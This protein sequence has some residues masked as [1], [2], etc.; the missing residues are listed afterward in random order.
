MEMYHESLIDVKSQNCFMHDFVAQIPE[1]QRYDS[2]YSPYSDCGIFGHYFFGDPKF[3]Q[4]M[5]YA[6]GI[7]GKIFSEY[8]DDIEVTRAKYKLYNELLSVQSAS[9]TMQ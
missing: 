8:L 3:D 9:D 2:I 7:A 6:G 4:H 1:L 5:S